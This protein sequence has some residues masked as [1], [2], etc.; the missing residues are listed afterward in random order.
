MAEELERCRQVQSTSGSVT[1]VRGVIELNVTDKDA[2]EKTSKNQ[3]RYSFENGFPC[4]T[5]S[6]AY[7]R[8]AT[9]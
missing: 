9:I 1:W 8:V 2:K 3:E 5:N 7:I 4:S 6:C